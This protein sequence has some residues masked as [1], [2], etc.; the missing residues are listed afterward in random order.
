MDAQR[1]AGENAEQRRHAK[2]SRTMTPL[3]ETSHTTVCIM[4]MS[5]ANVKVTYVI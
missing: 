4:S 2:M 1:P 3:S 5:Y